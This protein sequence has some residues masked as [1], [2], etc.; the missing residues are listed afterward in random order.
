M[1]HRKVCPNALRFQSN[2]PERLM[3]LDWPSDGSHYA[4]SLKIVTLNRQGLLMDISTIFGE[5]QTNVS[6]AKIRTLPNHTAEIEVSI[7]VRDTQHLQVV[8]TKIG[9]FSDVISILRLF[10][11]VAGK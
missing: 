9:N 5:S 10:G 4:V 3:K 6:A 1:L 7:D 11:R 8:M 2:E